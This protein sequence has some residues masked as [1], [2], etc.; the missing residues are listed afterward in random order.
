MKKLFYI[1]TIAAFSSMVIASCT[2]ES[3]TPTNET[4]PTSTGGAGSGDPL[5]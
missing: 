5:K 2:E 1:L 4:T 3:V